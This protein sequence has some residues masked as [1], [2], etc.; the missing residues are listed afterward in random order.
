MKLI[1]NW[2]DQNLICHFC[3]TNKNVK[4]KLNVITINT[5]LTKI[6]K[7][8]C[9]CDN[10]VPTFKALAEAIPYKQ[11]ETELKEK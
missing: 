11:C 10:C 8:V 5:P 9:A 2:Q 7:E 6:E 4:Y 3:S 1:P